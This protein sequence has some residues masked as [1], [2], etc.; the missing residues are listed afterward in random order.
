MSKTNKELAVEL[1]AASLQATATVISNPNVKTA[2][3]K[4]P[5]LDDMVEQVRLLASKL[6]MIDDH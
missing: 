6:S 2:E 4:I 1:Y 5:T 3:V